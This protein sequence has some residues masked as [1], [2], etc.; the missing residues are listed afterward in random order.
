MMVA[1]VGRA[2]SDWK[3]MVAATARK[4]MPMVLVL[5]LMVRMMAR[6]A[7]RVEEIQAVSMHWTAGFAALH[8]RAATLR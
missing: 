1:P 7:M 6:K 5:V 8:C 3:R 2:S 4:W